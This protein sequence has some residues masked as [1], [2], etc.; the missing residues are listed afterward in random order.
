MRPISILLTIFLLIT[1]AVA[2]VDL[3]IKRRWLHQAIF[4]RQLAFIVRRNLPLV[5]SLFVSSAGQPAGVRHPMRRLGRLLELGIPLSDAIAMAWPRCPRVDR[6]ILQAAEQCGTLPDAI[7]IVSERY[8]RDFDTRFEDAFPIMTFPLIT[9]A[10]VLSWFYFATVTFIPNFV[11]ILVDFDT[12]MPQFS[13]EIFLTGFTGGTPPATWYGLL[14]HASLW[15]VVVT[16]SF[17]ILGAVFGPIVRRIDALNGVSNS[18]RWFIPV[19][20]R[21]EIARGCVETLPTIR[22]AAGAGWPLDR[23]VDLAA[24]IETNDLWCQRLEIWAES[25]R[26]GNDPIR[27]GRSARLPSILM[28]YLAVG[29]RDGDLEAPLYSA[30]QYYKLLLDRHLRTARLT[31]TIVATL[32]LGAFVACI[33]VASLLMLTALTD[34]ASAYWWNL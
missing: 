1:I 20:R 7:T 5:S 8:Q 34:T 3:V 28:R 14:F 16:S 9:L 10:I 25:I 17:W 33:C 31:Q 29:V 32:I 18:L 6:S 11:A 27:A 4:M 21:A 23:A 22:I 19:C 26:A 13:K 24:S 15:I 2:V 30:E 12:T